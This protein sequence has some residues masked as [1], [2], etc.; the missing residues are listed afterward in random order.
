MGLS[1]EDIYEDK[2]DKYQQQ[3]Y[4][5]QIRQWDVEGLARASADR[6]HEAGDY[7]RR[8][9]LQAPA[10]N[11]RAGEGSRQSSSSVSDGGGGVALDENGEY[12]YAD[13]PVLEGMFANVGG[14]QKALRNDD[15][16]AGDGA[17]APAASS[18]KLGWGSRLWNGAKA[19]GGFIKNFTGYNAVRHGIAGAFRKRKIR[20]NQEKLDAAREGLDDLKAGGYGGGPHGRSLQQQFD[21]AERKVHFN[22]LK[23]GEHRKYR[24]GRE[25]KNE[26]SRLFT[27]RDAK[28]SK[29]RE[30]YQHGFD[31]A[32]PAAARASGT[33]SSSLQSGSSEMAPVNAPVE[34]PVAPLEQQV[35]RSEPQ[36][37][38]QQPPAGHETL[39]E[40]NGLMRQSDD[41]DDDGDAQKEKSIRSLT[42][43][44]L[45]QAGQLPAD[46]DDD[47]DDYQSVD[48]GDAMNN[49]MFGNDD[50]DD[51]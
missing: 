33:A 4:D 45:V 2:H 13:D 9:P 3:Y 47:Q 8:A 21:E 7:V 43:S 48:Y 10:N 37:I 27:G 23:L 41:V 15:D 25:W 31:Y 35:Q 24:T 11:G 30:R 51:D 32:D 39:E 36:P 17:A 1:Y 28:L 44:A 22:R 18:A 40:L 16:E 20:K 42:N 50:N 26:W 46:Q 38:P 49:H 29:A 14:L 19:L 6:A 12:T 5:G 34:V